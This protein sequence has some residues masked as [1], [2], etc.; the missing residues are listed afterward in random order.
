MLNALRGSV[1]DC[2]VDS[3]LKLREVVASGIGAAGRWL[4]WCSG[5]RYPPA[6][7]ANQTGRRQGRPWMRLGTFGG[8]PRPANLTGGFFRSQDRLHGLD[9][10]RAGLL[11]AVIRLLH[12]RVRKRERQ[13]EPLT[14]GE[15]RRPRVDAMRALDDRAP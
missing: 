4:S 8:A 11:P 2:L 5:L 10:L 14:S 15:A 7:A 3:G 9:Q 6:A 12:H 1:G 13:A